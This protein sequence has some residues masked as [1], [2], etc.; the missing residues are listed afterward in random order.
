VL[1]ALPDAGL[2]ERLMLRQADLL[3]RFA[4]DMRRFVLKQDASQR[5]ALNKEELGAAQRGARALVGTPSGCIPGTK[6]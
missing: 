1:A 5:W 4:D 6:K 2:R 3:E